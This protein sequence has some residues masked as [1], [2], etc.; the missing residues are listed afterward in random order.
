MIRKTLSFSLALI[1]AGF[2]AVVAGTPVLAQAPQGNGRWQGQRG[3]TPNP[4]RQAQRLAKELNLS[5]D[6]ESR[7]VAIL[8]DRDQKMVALRSDTSLTHES[9]R[10]QMRGIMNNTR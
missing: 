2:T 1:V 5:P 10:Q 7:L 6:Q 3:H 4:Q 9:R 8:A